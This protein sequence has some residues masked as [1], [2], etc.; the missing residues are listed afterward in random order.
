M[1]NKNQA[2]LRPITREDIPE[3]HVDIYDAIGHTAFMELCYLCGGQA[4]Y[5][6]KVE[7]L[8]RNSRDEQI[9][10]LFNG[11]NYRELAIQYRLSER[12]IRKIINGERG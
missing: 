9:R 2:P 5:V 6:P 12:Q 3:S 7:S 11:G 1:E 8:Q 4:L 10:A